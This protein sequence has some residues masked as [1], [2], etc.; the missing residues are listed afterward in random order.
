MAKALVCDGPD[1]NSW[2]LDMDL[3]LTVK[4]SVMTDE[5]HFCLWD[6]VLRYAAQFEPTEIIEVA[7]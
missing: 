6:C 4:R 2:S 5:L 1:C 3:F 7:E